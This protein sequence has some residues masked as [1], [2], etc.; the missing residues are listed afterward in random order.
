MFINTIAFNVNNSIQRA[1]AAGR[2]QHIAL[3]PLYSFLVLSV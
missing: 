3:M 1:F 2:W